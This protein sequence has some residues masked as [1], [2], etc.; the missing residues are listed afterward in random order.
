MASKKWFQGMLPT[1]LLV[2]PLVAVSAI[3]A[4]TPAGAIEKSITSRPRRPSPTR[5]L[6]NVLNEERP[7]PI[8]A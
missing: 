8:A 1:W 6:M 2:V 3:S 7:T 4:V 5:F